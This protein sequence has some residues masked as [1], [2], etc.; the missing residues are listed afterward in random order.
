MHVILL[1]DACSVYANTATFRLMQEFDIG[2]LGD[3]QGTAKVVVK[4]GNIVEE[5][6]DVI[7]VSVGST[8]QHSDDVYNALV[9]AGGRKAYKTAY[10]KA[11]GELTNWLSRG[12]ILIVDTSDTKLEAKYVFLVVHPDVFHL[13]DAYRN[14]FREAMARGCTSV[15]IPGLG[16]GSIGNSVHASC[17]RACEVLHQIASESLGSIQKIVFIDMKEK[18]AQQFIAQMEAKFGI[19]DSAEALNSPSNSMENFAKPPT[20]VQQD[21]CVICLCPLSESSEVSELPCKHQLHTACLKE[22]LRSANVKKRCPVCLRYFELPLGDQPS[23]ARMFINK[24]NHIKLPGHEDSDFVYEIIYSV[25]NG[26]QEASHIR[27]GRPFTGTHRRAYVPGTAEGTKVLRLL[28]FAF[29]RRL[30]FTVGKFLI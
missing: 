30:I 12:E 29:D 15:A 4:S 2:P 14:I 22:Y 26:I 10:E 13:E 23:E 24:L 7:C 6:V 9:K 25:P 18:V 8:L 11:R 16:C 21:D 20:Y 28:K 1:Y 19:M 3:W 27:P 17:S 5:K